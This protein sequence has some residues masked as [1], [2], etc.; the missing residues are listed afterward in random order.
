MDQHNRFLYG[1]TTSKYD[2]GTPATLGTSS[3]KFVGKAESCEK[4]KTY[5][6]ECLRHETPATI[7]GPAVKGY[8]GSLDEE[9]PNCLLVANGTPFGQIESIGFF[10]GPGGAIIKAAYG[11]VH[12]R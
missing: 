7:T 3:V 9:C 2:T 1:D 5:L 6:D 12:V 8:W 11:K 4:A 10:I